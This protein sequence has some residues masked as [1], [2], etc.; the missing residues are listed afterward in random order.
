[1]QN[2]NSIRCSASA[3]CSNAFVERHAPDVTG[4]LSGWDRM[5]VRG[6]LRK[7][8]YPRGMLGYLALCRIL[9]KDF[10]AFTVG[11]TARILEAASGRNAIAARALPG[12]REV[13]QGEDR[14]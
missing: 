9:L 1:M 13:V 8:Y 3:A 11:L 4:M 10:K 5:V 2:Q 7:L 12:Q 14:P 6:T